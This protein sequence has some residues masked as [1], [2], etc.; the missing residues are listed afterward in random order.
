M[1]GMFGFS[2]V[3][4]VRKR[5][6]SQWISK[7]FKSK[8][9]Q[10][11]N[12]I[13]L[14]CWVLQ[15]KNNPYIV[16]NKRR[17]LLLIHGFGTDGLFGWDTQICALGKHFDLL[18]P[19][20]IFFGN[21]TTTS[22]QR[23]EIFQA[24]CM[25]SMVE[26]LGVES[27]IVVGHSYGGFV[28]FWMAHN[29]PNV[30]RRLVIVSSAIC[31]TPSTN[32]T[33]LKKMGSSDIKDVLLPNNSGDIRKAMNITFYKKSWLPT[34]IYE[35]F[36]QTMGGNREKKAELLDAIVIG[37]ENSNL[38]PTVNQDVLIVWG[39][40][41]RTFGL[42]QAFLLQRHIGEKA[43]LAVIKECGHVPQLEK[44]T[45]LNETLLNFLLLDG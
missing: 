7:G 3:E 44:P 43:Q 27:V 18:I 32:N 35:D 4:F 13:S 24:E 10:L 41:D 9:I 29:Y 37:S 33:L 6:R 26:Y 15:I 42:E 31:M 2:I 5:K 19:D 39:E 25:K 8:I 36:L 38:L 40:K 16:K 20:L 23:S 30:V 17:A 34:C 21:S 11:S 1:K 22:S 28:A 45:E 12:G 14:H